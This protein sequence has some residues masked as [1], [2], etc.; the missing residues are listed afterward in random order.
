MQ[1]ESAES[2]IEML[3]SSGL[4][5]AEP[6]DKLAA[7]LRAAGSDPQELIRHLI[8]RERITAYQLRRVVNGRASELFI[9][10][11]VVLDKLGEGGM[12]RVFRARHVRQDRQIALKV[13]REQVL[14]KPTARGRYDRE[15]QA[16]LALKHPNIVAVSSAGSTRGFHRGISAN[17]VSAT[18]TED[19]HPSQVAKRISW[20]VSFATCLYHQAREQ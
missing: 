14:S 6:F 1:I 7:E 9:G 13:V 5:E 16:A 15:V 19:R 20:S 12:G 11:Y 18:Q 10:P 8:D 3:R 2:L 4:Y 17:T